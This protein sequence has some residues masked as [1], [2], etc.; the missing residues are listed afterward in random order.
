MPRTIRRVSPPTVETLE[1]LDAALLELQRLDGDD[2]ADA[3]E[4]RALTAEIE[5]GIAAKRFVRIGSAKVPAADYR[6]QLVDAALAYVEPRKAE[7]LAGGKGKTRQLRNGSIAWR[8]RPASL[9][10]LDGQASTTLARFQ[11]AAFGTV[12]FL[13]AALGWLVRFTIAGVAADQVLKLELKVDRRKLLALAESG[14]ADADWLAAHNLR[15]ETE[16]EDVV[17]KPLEHPQASAVPLRV[18][19]ARRAA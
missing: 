12:G 11:L 6:T 4:L 17:L 3:A 15:L 8:K 10:D 19:A 14:K 5:A 1:D 18:A 16:A 7:L 13:A 9:V 2:A